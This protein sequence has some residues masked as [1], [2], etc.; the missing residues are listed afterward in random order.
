MFRGNLIK[1]YEY[2]INQNTN[3]LIL[4]LTQHINGTVR[5]FFYL[6][7]FFSGSVISIF[8]ILYLIYLNPELS[9]ISFIIFGSYYLLIVNIF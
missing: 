5:G 1:D 4:T 6:L 3:K 7:Q 2:H 8:I 9:F